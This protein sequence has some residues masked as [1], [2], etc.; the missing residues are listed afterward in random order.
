MGPPLTRP[1]ITT[2][3]TKS[4]WCFLIISLSSVVRELTS[5]LARELGAWLRPWVLCGCLPRYVKRL[6]IASMLTDE[7]GDTQQGLYKVNGYRSL[8]KEHCRG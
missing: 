4:L 3:L 1:C 5:W 7:A 2:L 6:Q 8:S